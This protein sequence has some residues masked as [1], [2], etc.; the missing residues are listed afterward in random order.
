MLKKLLLIFFSS[1][2][3]FPLF[4]GKFFHLWFDKVAPDKHTVAG[5]GRTMRQAD[6]A[7]VLATEKAEDFRSEI[8]PEVK[9]PTGDFKVKVKKFPEKGYMDIYAMPF[10]NT[11]YPYPL[12]A[13]KKDGKNTM[14]ASLT[15]QGLTVSVNGESVT[16]SDVDFPA[17]H[18]RHVQLVWD[19][20]NTRIFIERK[21]RAV[22]KSS[23]PAA[24]QAVLFAGF[25]GLVDE[26]SMGGG[27]PLT[28][29]P[30]FDGDLK[31]FPEILPAK[32]LLRAD[33]WNSSHRNLRISQKGEGINFSWKGFKKGLA[34]YAKASNTIDFAVEENSFIRGDFCWLKKS[35]NYASQMGLR[36][37]F[38]NASG[39]VIRNMSIDGRTNIKGYV[40][41]MSLSELSTESAIGVPMSYF[42]YYAVPAGAVKLRFEMTFSGNPFEVLLSKV[43]FRKIDPSKQPWFREPY[44][45]QKIHETKRLSRAEVA[46][47][48]E[49]RER[50][51]PELK[52]IGDRVEIFV[53]GK[54]TPCQ[55]FINPAAGDYRWIHGF[56]AAGFPFYLSSVSLG[57]S[58]SFTEYSPIWL[59]DGTIDITPLKEAVYKV[60]R[61][62]P[63]AMIFLSLSITPPRSYL[64]ENKAELMVNSKGEYAVMRDF[65]VRGLYSK[66]FPDKIGH[67]WY[68]STASRKYRADVA[69]IIKKALGEFEK[70]PESKVVAGIYVT[71]GDDGQFRFPPLPDFSAPALKSY[72]EFLK[73]LGRANADTAEMPD[74]ENFKKP[75][76][77]KYGSS[78][79]ADYQMWSTL[80]S[81]SLRQSMYQAVKNGMPRVLVGGYENAMALTGQPGFGRYKIGE[82]LRS[83]TPDF[84]ISLPGYNRYRDDCD[85][86]SGMKAFNGSMVLHNKLMIGEMDIR[87]PENGPLGINNRSR[88]YQATHNGDTFRNFLALYSSYCISWGGGFHA[89]MMQPMWWNTERAVAAWVRAAEITRHAKGQALDRN[90]VA[91]FGD[92]NSSY[93]HSVADV[94]SFH[95]RV[96]YREGCQ[97]SLWRSGVRCDYYLMEDALHKNFDAPKIMLFAEAGTMTPDF[98]AQ[99]R[100]KWGRDGRIIIFVG[101]AGYLPGGKV[102]D[103]EQITNFK[104]KKH[105]IISS[106]LT[107][108]D[109]KVWWEPAFY[110]GSFP[111][112]VF[113]IT[114]KDVE[115]LAYYG[116]SDRVGAA[117]KK[118]PDHTEIYFGQPGNITPDFIR[119]LA[120]KCGITPV[121]QINDLCVMGGGLLEIGAMTG[122]GIRRINFPDGVK[123]LTL[124]TGQKIT[125]QGENFI[126]VYL[127]YKDAAVF[128][129]ER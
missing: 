112:P 119:T 100:Q 121:Q 66:E 11:T 32:N 110:A 52:R 105:N 54:L 102:E 16:V 77:P 72:R 35:W 80:E 67:S 127:P 60:L 12:A 46:A 22:L 108:L 40:F 75:P 91:V 68:P 37:V 18:Y 34:P 58:C 39:K 85:H 50:I 57:R 103:I 128:K 33:S 4:A 101:N 59:E 86:P 78:P 55:I 109:G 21:E 36:V 79:V 87:N 70:T 38:Y 29:D 8:A 42:N 104:L 74:P 84:L 5:Y 99:I 63:D 116:N 51:F 30:E 65:A 41:P 56:K 62:A 98:A 118:Y 23:P 64:E 125:A 81:Y 53:N 120:K 19:G 24:D 122:A 129:M 49:K 107:G 61:Y 17:Q 123:K 117:M 15:S 111:S 115:V 90:R 13:L 47:V 96:N 124:L 88:N 1:G 95:S 7:L 114:D 14:L 43:A 82:L 6:R 28:I 31:N 93:Y 20:K 71:G 25:Q 3:F 48:L 10:K 44:D 2:I 9:I 26:F 89:Y 73:K 97:Y 69:E 83:K 92:E 76:F 45:I 113:E 94:P 126:E 106:G 27:M